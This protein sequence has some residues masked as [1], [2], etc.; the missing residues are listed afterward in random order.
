MTTIVV[1]HSI[2]EVI[3]QPVPGVLHQVSARVELINCSNLEF[4]WLIV[5]VTLSDHGGAGVRDSQ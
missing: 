2:E 5:I 1:P 3:D 4:D